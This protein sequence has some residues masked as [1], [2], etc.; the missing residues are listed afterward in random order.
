MKIVCE[1]C[2]YELV[3]AA[4]FCSMCGKDVPQYT[5]ILNTEEF[6]DKWDYFC[7]HCSILI[8]ESSMY[9]YNCGM[10]IYERPFQDF[11]FCPKCAAENRKDA[12][13]CH[14]CCFSIGEWFD[15]KSTALQKIGLQGDL[16]L[17]DNFTSVTYYFFTGSLITVGRSNESDIH[18]RSPY[19]SK[20]H[21]QF[22]LENYLLVD[23]G[24]TNGTYINRKSSP[25]RTVSLDEV[26]EINIADILTFR[27]LH[28]PN[29]Y[30]FFLH[31]YHNK[32]GEK[33]GNIV[34][35]GLYKKYFILL[36]GDAQ[37]WFRKIDG[38]IDTFEKQ[39][40][41]FIISY[42]HNY[43]FLSDSGRNISKRIITKFST[44]ISDN[45]EVKI[46]K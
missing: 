30:I 10:K 31:S 3:P 45:L 29:T 20:K 14:Q 37:L 26:D 11:L 19:I 17:H 36:S 38:N 1:Q 15:D 39:E 34:D 25:I 2:G 7:P 5:V 4:N 12:I 18:I 23:C 46:G 9:C 28:L 35:K 24:S 44:R 6:K 40:D 41:C 43:Y 32:E 33:D 22:D 13:I 16:I 27:V 21:I 42:E 8:P